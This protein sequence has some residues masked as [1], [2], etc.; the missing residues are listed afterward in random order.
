LLNILYKHV[1]EVRGK[2]DYAELSTPLTTRDLANYPRGEL[3]GLA[4]TPERFQQKWLRPKTSVKNLYLT[5]QD[6][7]SAGVTGALFAGVLTT[8]AI[9]KKNV[10]KA[11][12]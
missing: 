10:M 5:G 3:Y 8:S 7:I 2:V 12:P 4:H 1:P 6:I 9:L 11:M